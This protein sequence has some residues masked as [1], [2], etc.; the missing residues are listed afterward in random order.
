[1]MPQQAPSLWRLRP[2]VMS[3]A[4]RARLG[5]PTI[6]VLVLAALLGHYLIG[7]GTYSVLFGGIP[8]RRH[9][10]TVMALAGVGLVAAFS[11]GIAAAQSLPLTLLV[12]GIVT[13][14]GVLLDRAIPL[15]PASWRTG[16]GR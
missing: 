14:A 13:V 15:G 6:A 1:M 9:R 11:L 8:D 2:P 3:L 10:A 16:C 5:L 7:L 12:F 4:D